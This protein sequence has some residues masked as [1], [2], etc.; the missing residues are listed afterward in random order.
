[1]KIIPFNFDRREYFKIITLMIIKEIKYIL[2]FSPSKKINFSENRFDLYLKVVIKNIKSS[3][4]S[5][6]NH[7]FKISNLSMEKIFENGFDM[8]FF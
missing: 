6:T 7:A 8:P 4:R 1:M 3:K 5:F 2:T